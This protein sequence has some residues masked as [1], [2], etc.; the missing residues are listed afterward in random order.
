V[1]SSLSQAVV[2][3]TGATGGIGSALVPLLAQAGAHLVLA[4]RREGP[5]A[6]LAEKAVALGAASGVG[7]PTDVTDYAQVEAL[8]TQ[9]LQRHG[10]ID[11]LNQPRRRRHPQTCPANYPR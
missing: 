2:L 1:S 4:A 6:T 5:L 7:I 11:V 8:V 10:R 3:I 9:T